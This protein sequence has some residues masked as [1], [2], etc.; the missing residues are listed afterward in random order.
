MASKDI[1]VSTDLRLSIR[2][3]QGRPHSPSPPTRAVEDSEGVVSEI[4][5]PPPK[6][7]RKAINCTTALCYQ[8]Q[9]NDPPQNDESRRSID[10]F[11]EISRIRQSLTLLEAHMKDSAGSRPNFTRQTPTSLRAPLTGLL[12]SSSRP[13]ID[14]LIGHR[15]SDS[16]DATLVD[17]KP[18]DSEPDTRPGK[19]GR[20]GSTGLYVGPT[21]P[22]S[23]LFS[24]SDDDVSMFIGETELGPDQADGTLD[25]DTNDPSSSE[26]SHSTVYDD[27]LIA[28]LPPVEVVD[29]LIAYYFKYCN[30]I[31]RH[32]DETALL[33][34]WAH[35]KA[36]QGSDRLILGTVCV[37]IC[38]AIYYLPPGHALL[39]G[40]PGPIDE[41]ARRYHGVMRVALKR[42]REE[43]ESP[44]RM[45]T[46]PFVEL[47]LAETHLLA[48]CRDDPEEIWSLG[49]ELV[50][51]A[52][53]M[54]LHRDPA[55]I[56]VGSSVAERRRW[57][58][59]HIILFERW[60][61]FMFG[62]PLHIATH[63]FDTQL[64]TQCDSEVDESGRRY[65]ASLAFFRLAYV[66]GE[67]MD[68]AVSFR[69][70]SYSSI[71][72]KDQLLT[73]WYDSLPPELC[74]E[75]FAL[76]RE[77]GSLDESARRAAVQSVVERSMYYH[78]RFAM[79]RPYIQVQ[80]SLEIAVSSASSL[81]NLFSNACSAPEV[82]GHLIWGPFHVFA[83]AMFFSFQLVTN[84][85]QPGS[86][87][88]REQ[89]TRSIDLLERSRR[90]PLVESALALLLA[91]KPLYSDQ[92]ATKSLEE[93]EDEK[94][95][96]L[97]AVAQ[98]A[99]P[100]QE[101]SRAQ[102][103]D[104]SVAQGI[105]RSG[106]PV[107][108]SGLD[109]PNPVT[110]GVERPS[111][112]SIRWVPAQSFPQMGHYSHFS[113]SQPTPVLMAMADQVPVHGPGLGHVLFPPQSAAATQQSLR[114]T[115]VLMSRL[116]RLPGPLTQPIPYQSGMSA[117]TQQG[118][119]M[120]QQS[121]SHPQHVQGSAI[122]GSAMYAPLDE[123]TLWHG[124]VGLGLGEWAQLLSAMN[125][126]EAPSRQL[127]P[128]DAPP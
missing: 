114:R 2:R 58:W 14:S 125:Q 66:L 21:S 117:Y 74:L 80:E 118:V 64:P 76:V 113:S 7:S 116:Q 49:G 108:G 54:G 94:E 67:I 110:P 57:A 99:F 1:V 33:A 25:E 24:T 106:V 73:S 26:P 70:V 88:F 3:K 30:W 27:D 121:L 50:S 126:S 61:A 5:Q 111:S 78:V 8:G 55:N 92:W 82:H 47:L 87:L 31:Y 123:S 52:T 19:L 41:H 112:S 17:R 77:L 43:S 102:D 128:T 91:L 104:T 28:F 48:F 38:L 85:D 9:D 107:V 4:R 71:Q 96:V 115:P 60:Q 12:V 86:G 98:L 105:L 69:S 11:A 34:G 13:S 68:D 81:I 16:S 79:H 37:I 15:A 18:P 39:N 95:A 59:W 103:A 119:N 62:R 29:G 46:L 45:Y 35:Y 53:A 63:H 75:G 40:L 36:G 109:T 6:R 65:I 97:K 56:D 101:S 89:V 44:A 93:R 23:M 83:A 22:V 122:D 42:Y 100:W 72:E 20:R 124:S 10:V 32:V 84:P 51:I 90:L 127:D 120:M